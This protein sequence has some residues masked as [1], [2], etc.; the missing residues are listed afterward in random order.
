MVRRRRNALVN[1]VVTGKRSLDRIP[2]RPAQAAWLRASPIT[3]VFCIRPVFSG[4]QAFLRAPIG[5]TS[6]QFWNDGFWQE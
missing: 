6:M 3:T 5:H 2:R 4:G 1:F